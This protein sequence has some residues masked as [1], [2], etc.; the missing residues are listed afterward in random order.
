ME[1]IAQHPVQE[2]GRN[3]PRIRL[4]Q[5]HPAHRLLVLG[6]VHVVYAVQF[7]KQVG[8]HPLAV[9][10]AVLVTPD[11][12]SEFI[13]TRSTHHPIRVISEVVELFPTFMLRNA[14]A[15]VLP[16]YGPC[17]GAVG[18]DGDMEEGEDGGVQEYHQLVVRILV[19]LHL[20][21]DEGGVGVCN[22]L[23]AVVGHGGKIGLIAVLVEEVDLHLV[24][25]P[26]KDGHDVAAAIRIAG[27]P[28]GAVVGDS[29]LVRS[30]DVGRCRASC[31]E[32]ILVQSVVVG[33]YATVAVRLESVAVQHGVICRNACPTFGRRGGD[34]IAGLPGRGVAVVAVGKAREELSSAYERSEVYP[35]K[36]FEQVCK[37]GRPAHTD[38]NIRYHEVVIA[39]V[40]FRRER[41]VLGSVRMICGEVQPDGII[42]ESGET[43]KLLHTVASGLL[44]PVG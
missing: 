28:A 34:R 16:V 38:I 4:E 32:R 6:D 10:A 44:I 41:F 3:G 42:V 33:D 23:A 7:R 27:S 11:Y 17:H 1:H 22:A 21:G 13:F 36:D 14:G 29:P 19:E 25:Q 30:V 37:T 5:L 12:I 8:H 35:V 31:G 43:A 40:D 9:A 15:E 18:V 39:E 24:D 2:R 20:D 26:V